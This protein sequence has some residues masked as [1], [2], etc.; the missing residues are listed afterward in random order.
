MSRAIYWQAAKPC[1]VKPSWRYWLRDLLH[2]GNPERREGRKRIRP[3]DDYGS[4]SQGFYP[5]ALPNRKSPR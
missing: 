3:G 2:G 4:W 1:T 5:A